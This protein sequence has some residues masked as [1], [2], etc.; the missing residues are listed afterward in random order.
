MWPHVVCDALSDLVIPR[1]QENSQPCG[2]HTVEVVG[3]KSDNK[4]LSGRKSCAISYT[5][6]SKEPTVLMLKS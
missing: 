1:H 4:C 2:H 6:I 3:I 5:D